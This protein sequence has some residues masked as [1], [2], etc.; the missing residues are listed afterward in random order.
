[1]TGLDTYSSAVAYEDGYSGKAVRLGDYGLKLNR[2][3]LGE[4]FTVSLW[5]KPDGTLAVNQS[6]VFL[7]YHSPKNGWPL[8]V[9]VE[10]PPI[11]NSGP[12]AMAMA[13]TAWAMPISPP[14]AGTS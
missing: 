12:T 6:V 13:G 8:Q 14:P 7:G 4:N 11:A 10:I 9:T 5:L 1:M 2:Q 3:N